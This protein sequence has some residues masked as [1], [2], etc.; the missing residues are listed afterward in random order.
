MASELEAFLSSKTMKVS[1]LA[2]VMV[3]VAVALK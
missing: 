2:F 3:L 1:V